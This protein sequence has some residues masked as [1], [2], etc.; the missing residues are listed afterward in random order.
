MSG[1]SLDLPAELASAREARRFVADCAAGLNRPEVVE[2]AQ[3][4]VSELVTNA[5]SHAGTR[6][7][8]ECALTEEGLR[9]SVCDG[10]SHL[11]SPG[12]PDAWDEKG[13]GL[14]LVDILASRW[15]T[16]RHPGNGKAVWFQLG[17]Q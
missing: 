11:P 2:T 17:Y 15:G 8:V 1:S 16:Q 5:V 3:L 6:V 14:M 7:E 13:R 12:H 10:S 9:V 4:L